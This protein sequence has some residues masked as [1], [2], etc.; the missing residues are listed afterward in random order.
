M[1]FDARL[2]TLDNLSCTSEAASCTSKEQSCMSENP[3]T[4]SEDLSTTCG[5]DLVAV[6]MHLEDSLMEK[7]VPMR[8]L[9]RM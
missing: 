6:E 1:Q 2:C 9:V 7:E 4:F 5:E 3:Q 8:V